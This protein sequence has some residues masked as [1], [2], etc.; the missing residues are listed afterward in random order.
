MKKSKVISLVIVAGLMASCSSHNEDYS[1]KGR[2]HIR[3]D[4]ISDYTRTNAYYGGGWF[5]H[6]YPYGFYSFGHGYYHGGYDSP[7]FS[8]RAS[9][10][11][12][13]GGFGSSGIR[14]GG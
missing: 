14:V 5:Y 7:G 13:R 2:L 3:G 8:S 10:G 4:S 6:F 9:N 1:Y 12:S 11:I